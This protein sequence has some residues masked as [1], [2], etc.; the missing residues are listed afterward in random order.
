MIRTVLVVPAALAV[1]AL[2]ACTGQSDSYPG[3]AG[4]LPY[5]ERGIDQDIDATHGLDTPTSRSLGTPDPIRVLD[6]P[7][8]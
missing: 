2:G 1:L 8:E 7:S 6:M 5:Y 3:S 4:Y